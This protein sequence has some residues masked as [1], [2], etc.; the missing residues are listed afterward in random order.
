MDERVLRENKK[1]MFQ[2]ALLGSNENENTIYQNLW[3]TIKTI[4][5]GMFIPLN[6]DIKKS[7]GLGSSVVKKACCFSRGP[8]F[9]SQLQGI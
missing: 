2:K 1:E 8:R 9:S 6:A 3:G 7:E 5:R 4:L